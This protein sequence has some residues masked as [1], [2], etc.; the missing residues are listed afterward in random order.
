MR[1][2]WHQDALGTC[3]ATQKVVRK[4]MEELRKDD[5]RTISQ[6]KMPEGLTC[7]LEFTEEKHTVRVNSV[8]VA[9]VTVT[10]GIL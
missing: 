1:I 4:G 9:P 7:W 8:P 5:V 10:E 2:V 6:P 3:L